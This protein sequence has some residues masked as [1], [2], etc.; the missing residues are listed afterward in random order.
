M[1][2]LLILGRFYRKRIK[3]QAVLRCGK[4]TIHSMKNVVFCFVLL[5]RYSKNMSIGLMRTL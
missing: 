2:V 1:S 3:K 5:F 4:A